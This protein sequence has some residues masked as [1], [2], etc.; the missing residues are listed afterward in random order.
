MVWSSWAIILCQ[1]TQSQASRGEKKHTHTHTQRAERTHHR[2]PTLKKVGIVGPPN[3]ANSSAQVSFIFWAHS[4][5]FPPL[6]FE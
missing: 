5:F 4:Y 6:F 1:L 3:P 2:W